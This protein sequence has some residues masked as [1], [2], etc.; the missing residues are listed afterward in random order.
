MCILLPFWLFFK[1]QERF[2]NPKNLFSRQNPIS[3]DFYRI[4]VNFLLEAY[5]RL[6]F[7]KTAFKGFHNNVSPLAVRAF[8]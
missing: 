2:L 8:K 5:K 6:G 1:C 3:S 7:K 4:V